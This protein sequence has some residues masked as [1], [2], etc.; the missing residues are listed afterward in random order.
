MKMGRYYKVMVVFE[1]SCSLE[2]ISYR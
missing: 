2:W 1:R